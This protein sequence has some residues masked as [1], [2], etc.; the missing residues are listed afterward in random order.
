VEAG[1]ANHSGAIVATWLVTGGAGFIGSALVRRLMR[2]E[3]DRVVTV[4]K[5]T[6]AGNLDSLAEVLGDSR[7]HFAQLDV[8]D[9]AALRE[10]FARFRPDG[11]FHLAAE[12]HVDRS[13]D[14]PAAFIETNVVGTSTV[15]DE[16][17]RH[18]RALPPRDA[19]G[20]RLIHVSTDEVFGSLGRQGLFDAD[21]P[22]HPNSPYAASKAAGDHLAR[23]WHATYGL[24]VI[25][26]SCSNNYGPCQFPEKLI[27]LTIE[28][29]LAAEPI[30]VYGRGENIRDWLH[31]EDHIDALRAVMARGVPGA[32]YPVGA[33]N[34]RRNLDVV[35]AVCRV[36]DVLRPDP[37]G[38]HERRITL[39]P[40]RPGHDLRYAIDPTRTEQ[41]LGW[42]PAHPFD[43]GLHE[44][45]RWYVEHRTWVQRV[46]TGAYR[47]ERLGSGTR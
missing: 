9:G 19:A 36:L 25:V 13:I 29:A 27:P 40:D 22:Y 30:P 10:L 23:A 16:A 6:Y 20:F 28:R 18:W 41:E 43:I 4:D 1:D 42:K 47:G 7:H 31:V 37:A 32:T 45:V 5:L 46:T 24:P 17:L 21:S 39:V 8:C 12:S 14:A 44:T 33:R 34:E 2:S 15:L 38:P 35:R 26:T 11:V 3:G